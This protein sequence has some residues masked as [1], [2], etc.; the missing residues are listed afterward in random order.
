[1]RTI[2][3]TA[4]AIGFWHFIHTSGPA[5]VHVI[6]MPTHH[7]LFHTTAPTSAYPGRYPRPWLLGRSHPS[8]HMR[9]TT[10]S[11]SVESAR[12]VTP[13]LGGISQEAKA[14]GNAQDMLTW[15]RWCGREGGE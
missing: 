7:P 5:R 14:W 2:V 4:R 9:P 12:E 8:K 13:F 15:E 1:M 6:C 3:R 10:C 11:T